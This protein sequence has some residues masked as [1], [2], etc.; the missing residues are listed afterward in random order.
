M[1]SERKQ[2]KTIINP[3]RYQIQVQNWDLLFYPE[4]PCAS[5]QILAM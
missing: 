2:E 3:T 5:R 4:I 1:H